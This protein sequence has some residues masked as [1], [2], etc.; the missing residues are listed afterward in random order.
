MKLELGYIPITD[1]E[2]AE[3]SY[4]E[5]S[6]LYV[7]KEELSDVLLQDE[8]I[9]SVSFAIALPGDKTRITPLKML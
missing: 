7:S 8:N 2:F 9:S 3:R 5:G 1:I 6:T 4:V